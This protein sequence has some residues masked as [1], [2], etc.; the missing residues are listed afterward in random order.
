[1]KL[2]SKKQLDKIKAIY[3]PK[4]NFEKFNN[5]SNP[6]YEQYRDRQIEESMDKGSNNAIESVLSI[7]LNKSHREIYNELNELA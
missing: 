5:S 6:Q 3:Y 7:L 2:I 1:M 4:S